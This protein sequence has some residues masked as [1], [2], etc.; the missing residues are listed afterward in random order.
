MKRTAFIVLV[1]LNAFVICDRWYL[2]PHE[3]LLFKPHVRERLALLQSKLSQRFAKDH[4]DGERSTSQQEPRVLVKSFL[5]PQV[6]SLEALTANWTKFPARVFPRYV[7]LLENTVFK[8][9]TAEVALP[10]GSTALAI[11]F[12]EGNVLLSPSDSSRARSFKRL[13]ATDLRQQVESSYSVWRDEQ[14]AM[15]RAK[16]ERSN[17]MPAHAA[18]DANASDDGRPLRLADGSYPALL[19]SMSRLDV[20]EVSSK[21][22]KKWGEARLREVDG[23]QIWTVDVVYSA[24]VFCGEVDATAQ[25]QLRGGRVFRWIYPGSGETV[26]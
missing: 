20:V 6:E 17:A 1:A 9:G 2:A 21:K 15:A 26:P 12:S 16:W 25:A 7:T 11:S 4:R 3:S 18:K 13:D 23:E 24:T 8:M 22:I 10:A 14:I 19:Q 5:P